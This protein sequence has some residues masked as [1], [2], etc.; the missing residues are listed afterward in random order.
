MTIEL[1]IGDLLAGVAALSLAVLTV[2]T[3]FNAKA[4]LHKVAQQSMELATS[5]DEQ[6]KALPINSRARS[7]SVGL[8]N[9]LV[10]RSH[11]ATQRYLDKTTPKVL[12][13]IEVG[14]QTLIV[15]L[16]AFITW[17]LRGVPSDWE[18]W[19][20]LLAWTLIAVAI[21]ILVY[22][23]IVSRSHK[24]VNSKLEAKGRDYME[25]APE[26]EPELSPWFAFAAG[27]SLSAAALALVQRKVNK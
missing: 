2:V 4:R 11:H 17:T 20:Q 8:Y 22:G 7:R 5:L 14:A 6:V 26:P 12:T 1:N 25:E 23:L 18:L 15:L 10:F 13:L 24:S 3:A 19:R 21:G 9:D 16:L 27:L